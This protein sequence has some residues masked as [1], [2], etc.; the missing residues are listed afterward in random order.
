MSN[1][2]EVVLD[3][4]VKS[5]GKSEWRNVSR[6]SAMGKEVVGDGYIIIRLLSELYVEQKVNSNDVVNITRGGQQ[7]FLPRTVGEWIFRRKSGTFILPD[8]AKMEKM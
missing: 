2:V 6:A 1:Q 7:E 3:T 5:R 4:V 8:F